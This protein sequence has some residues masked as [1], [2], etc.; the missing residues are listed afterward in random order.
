MKNI[1]F[2]LIISLVSLHSA[3]AIDN[4]TQRINGV[5]QFLIE[6]ANENYLY[7]FENSIKENDDLIC[8]FG[9][10]VANLELGGLKELL[11]T[12]GLWKDSF[13]NDLDG[14]PNKATV[15]LV[16]RS[17]KQIELVARTVLEIDPETIETLKDK[18][19]PVS[20]LEKL[21][22]KDS[23]KTIEEAIVY[24]SQFN[25]DSVKGLKEKV[26]EIDIDDSDNIK[27]HMD[28]LSN[29]KEA[30]AKDIVKLD[31]DKKNIALGIIAA[32]GVTKVVAKS[33]DV[34]ISETKIKRDIEGLL[35]KIERIKKVAKEFDKNKEKDFIVQ[36]I[37]AFD[38]LREYTIE[39]DDSKSSRKEKEKEA[40][41]SI[42]RIKRHVLF[43]AQIAE[44]KDSK[45][46][47]ELLEVYTLP[48]V[49]FFEKRD[50]S[51][52]WFVTAYLGVSAAEPEDGG[53]SVYGEI[54][55]PIGL[56]YSWGAWDYR[57]VDSVSIMVAPFDFAYPVNL[58]LK[59]EEKDI[60]YDEIIAPSI[61]IN[62]GIE[63][64]PI[65]WGIVYQRGR[66]YDGSGSHD[67]R[68]LIHISFDMPLHVF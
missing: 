11:M 29:I 25:I 60:D 45:S 28:V 23:K 34:N 51:R 7:F 57:L 21:L 58:K 44:A 31:E 55:A 63:D 40:Q 8:Y 27:K 62:F 22:E 17:F 61:S 50:N 19:I 5:T 53:D 16:G 36:S 35:G 9:K 52:H 12:N 46:T 33:A 6:R 65:A 64:A 68:R 4:T 41:K 2:P 47:K 3:Y 30:L 13:K 66:A 42:N 38:L 37:A 39:S 24:F 49:S 10:T 32:I 20:N 54:Y 67:Y 59:G 48:A 15:W 18:N 43:F 56:E 14:I 1:L 26:C